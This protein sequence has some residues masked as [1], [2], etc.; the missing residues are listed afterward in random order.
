MKALAEQI[1]ELDSV[2]IYGRV[3]G[4]RGLMVEVRY[5]RWRCT[6]TWKN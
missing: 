6:P 3:V 1:A 5:R 4:V 2:E